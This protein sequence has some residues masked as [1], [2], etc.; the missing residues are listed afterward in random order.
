MSREAFI[1]A[2]H[3]LTN[4]QFTYLTGR[5][6]LVQVREIVPLLL[7]YNEC[8]NINCNRFKCRSTKSLMAHVTLCVDQHGNKIKTC[9]KCQALAFKIA[10]H[11]KRCPDATCKVP[12]CWMFKYWYTTGQ[13]PTRRRRFV[14][15]NC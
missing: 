11:A 2:I 12:A 8:K 1:R 9:I 10:L 15:C 7:H 14:F 5:L 6:M 4:D 13:A 3:T